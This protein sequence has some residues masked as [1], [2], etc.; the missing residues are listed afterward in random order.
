LLQADYNK[1]EINCFEY[2]VLSWDQSGT[3]HY[4]QGKELELLFKTETFVGGDAKRRAQT[5]SIWATLEVSGCAPNY[6]AIRVI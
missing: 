5:I 4:S 3:I 2:I 6:L 1:Y